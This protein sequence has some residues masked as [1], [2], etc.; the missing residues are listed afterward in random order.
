MVMKRLIYSDKCD[1]QCYSGTEI[2]VLQYNRY[3]DVVVL[4]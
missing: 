4:K 2:A 1:L 3:A